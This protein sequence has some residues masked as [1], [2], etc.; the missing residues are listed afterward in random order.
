MKRV[1]VIGLFCEGKEVSDG[2]SVKTR[3]V[4]QELEKA[5][6]SDNVRRIDTYGW[7][8]NPIKLLVNC[9]LSVW[10]SSNVV[11]LTDEGGIKVF[12]WLLC[13]ANLFHKSRLHYVVIG[14]WLVS[15]LEKHA[16]LTSCLKKMDY[17]F[18]ETSEMQKGLNALG[19]MNVCFMPNFKSLTPLKEEQLV[20]SLEE[21]YR[22]C[23]FS[24]VM[25]EKGIED[26]VNAI[27]R[28]NT[29]FGRTV[30]S[31]DVYGSIDP[32]QVEWFSAISADFPPEIRY[33]G[34]APFDKSVE[35][36]KKYFALLFPTFYPKE[37][38]PGTIID[39]YAAGVPVIA[40]RWSGFCDII[41][42]GCTGIGYPW[43]QNE[44][45]ENII[46]SIIYEPHLFLEM[47]KNCLRKAQD[48]IPETV[49]GTLI[50][51]LL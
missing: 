11:F 42:D 48:F 43:M 8:K 1:S 30:C 35:T 46:T 51:R 38:I 50:K 3:I 4:T 28:V 23:T 2:Q 31:L 27:N 36:I 32:D 25:R 18:A 33:C 34:V 16:L 47:K 9:V 13:C 39:A 20:Y 14:G 45:L 21:P 44:D 22:F 6:G 19:F 10:S 24:R 5:L 49:V 40:S 41:D 15:F 17:I 37:G 26:A 7:K 29:R 12:P